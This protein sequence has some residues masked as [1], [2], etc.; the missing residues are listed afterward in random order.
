MNPTEL[1]TL[2]QR[3]VANPH[4]Q[5]ALARAHDAGTSDPK[6]YAMFLEKVGAA[7]PDPAYASHWLSEAANVWSI[8]LGD[9]HRAARVLMMAVDKDPTQETAAERLA[10]LYR[11][12]GEHK[13]LVA[14]LERRVKAITPLAAQDPGMRAPLAAIH[15]ELGKVWSETPL[16]A[17]KKAIENYRRAIELDASSAY[18]IYALRELLKQA[19]Q[20][21][22]A[23]PLFEM[24]QVTVSDPERKVALYRD[25]AEVRKQAGDRAGATQV[26][27]QARGYAQ[28]D[29]ALVQELG[30]SI[31]ERIEANESVPP[32]ERQEAADL[33]VFL[34]ETYEGEYSLAYSFAALDCI[35]GQ[36]RAMQ[37]AA[38]WARSLGRA[39]ELPERW[40]AYLKANPAGA[41]AAEARR[42][43]GPAA[44]ARAPSRPAFNEPA[45]AG[46]PAEPQSPRQPSQADAEANLIPRLL[47]EA[48]ALLSRDRKPQALAKYKEVL[49]LDSAHPEALAWVEDYLRQRRQYAELRDVLMHAVRSQNASND[50]RKQQLRDVA[51]LCETQLRDLETAIQAWRQI[52]TI[53]RADTAAREHLRRLLERGGRWDELASVLEQEAIGSEDVEMKLALE[54]KLAQLHEMKRK[55]FVSAG[56][57]W[58]R[59]A[60]L[61]PGDESPIQTAIKL[62]E[63]GQRRDLACQVIADNAGAIEDKA[64]RA[65]LYHRLGDLREKSGDMAGAG[66]AYVLSAESD[67]G[68]PKMWEAAER[69]LTGGERWDRAAYAV[70]QRAENTPEPKARAVLL[71]RA[72]DLL[73]KAGDDA[74]GLLYLEGASALDPANESYSLAVEQ[75][76]EQAE[77]FTDMAEFLLARAEKLDDPKRRVV[78]RKRAADLQAQRL[79]NPDAAREIL[80]KALEDGDDA[81]IL[82]KLADDADGR[83]DF[84][85]EA[86]FLHRL[87]KLVQTP[88]EKNQIALKE[89]GILADSLDDVD[90]AIARYSWILEEVDPKNRD[91]IRKIVELEEKRDNQKGL[92][93]A[94]ERELGIAEDDADRLEISRKL[95]ML[96]EGTLDSPKDAIRA[97]D[98][99]H[100]LDAEDFE[101]TARLEL[102]CEKVEDWPRVAEFLTTLIE[103]EGDEEELSSL[104]RKLA[105]VLSSKLEKNDEALGALQGPADS[106]DAACRDAYVDLA[107]RLGWKGIVAQKLVEWHGEALP[108]PARNEALRG[109]FDR[110]LDVGREQDAAKVATELARSKGAD[111]EMAE[112]LEEIGVKLKDLE[113]ISVAHDLLSK[114]LSGVERAAELVRQAEVLVKADVDPIEAQQHGET[115]LGSVPPA[116]VE[117]LLSRLAA[118]TQAAGPVIDVYERQIARC[119]VPADRLGALAR[120]AQVAAVKGDAERARNFYELA[121]SGGAQDDTLLALETSAARGDE[122]RGDTLLRSTLAE[123]LSMGGQGSRDGG[124]TRC[125][126][127]RRAAQIAYRDLGDVNKAFGWLGDALVAH[128]DAGS[129]DALEELAEQAGDLKR[130]EDTLGR[131]LGE[132]FDGPLVRQL[133]ARRVKLRREKLNDLPGAAQDLK[134]LHDLSPGDVAVMDELSQLLT[135]LGDFRGMVHV[136]EDQIL[137]GKDPQARAELARKVARLWEE[138]L[139]D[140]REAADAWRRVLRMKPGDPDA[141]AGL[142][143]AKSDMLKQRQEEA[144]KPA[145]E[146][147]DAEEA[148]TPAPVAAKAHP[149]ASKPNAAKPHGRVHAQPVV[150]HDSAPE[151]QAPAPA[152][153]AAE[154]EADPEPDEPLE[155]ASDAAEDEEEILSVDDSELVGDDGEPIEEKKSPKGK[156]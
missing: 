148:G 114:E 1:D 60:A 100:K 56:E 127:L 147:D 21:Q 28:E 84:A 16:A 83:S 10:Q 112:R 62:L 65:S 153:A 90:G 68:G 38:H 113:A 93:D 42:E 46:A 81:E 57:A 8:T 30:A 151:A 124:R 66:E 103:V 39:N 141:Q 150:E 146:S 18:S 76:Y 149:A 9:A 142:E 32:A 13:A 14:L 67:G 152:E 135:E 139:K 108:T 78:L 51:G 131:A 85:Q 52:C 133:V 128:V 17:P 119:K 105:D 77:R 29:A 123:A 117:P 134:K 75:R 99:V 73:T 70:G 88:E 23:I 137:R 64:S 11:D 53:D 97:L 15:E 41:L 48:S 24:E 61:L 94:L 87:V 106:G 69:C 91:A 55:D 58:S 12:K 145:S 25:E 120:A 89:A 95:A 59:I 110:F 121:L 130:A 80:E 26:L 82:S 111:H 126:L 33:F 104:T 36:D 54:K 116:E 156:H 125:I 63:K 35:P 7:T 129:L 27:R 155:S 45:A 50:T 37:I 5:E 34:A 98:I 102:L 3:L 6:S 22:E 49:A 20:W 43:A 140:P 101:T 122:E 2:V 109:A 138:Q 118:L 72:A 154:P 31:L 74:N 144:A 92:A 44:P 132:V 47:E 40:A 71:V 107:D 136:L 19:Q 96:Y 86:E 4:D 115:G 143:R 79:D